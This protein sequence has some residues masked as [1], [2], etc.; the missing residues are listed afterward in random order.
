VKNTQK[1]IIKFISYLL[2]FKIILINNWPKIDP[3]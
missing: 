2:I 3:Q 1:L